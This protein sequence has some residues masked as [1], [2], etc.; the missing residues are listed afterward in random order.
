MRMMLSGLCLALVT[1]STL[2]AY[3]GSATENTA[4][5]NQLPGKG[6]ARLKIVRTHALLAALRDARIKLDGKQVASLSNGDSTII[7]IAAGSHEITADVWDSPQTSRV[8]VDAKPA[9]LYI[10]EVTP[11]LGGTGI[12]IFGAAGAAI[13]GGQDGGLFLIHAVSEKR[14]EH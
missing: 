12:G 13:A 6:T 9:T 1:A 11:N 8:R 4:R 3:A 2:N 5:S 10:F 14:I 7:D